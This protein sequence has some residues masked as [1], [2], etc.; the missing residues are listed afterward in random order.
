MKKI[1][2]FLL[3]GLGLW[4]MQADGQKCNAQLCTGRF[5]F[6]ARWQTHS[7]HCRGNA[8]SA[9]ATGSLACQDENGQGD[10]IKHYRHVRFLE[11]SRATERQYDF[12]GNNDIAAFVKTAQEEG[13]WVILRPSP[14]VCA[15]WEFGGYPYW[16]QEEEGLIVR[17]K[18][19]KYIA[20]YKNY[21]REIGTQLATLQI[22]HGGNILMVQ[23]ENEYGFTATIR[24]TWTLT[25]K[26][27]STP[28]LMDSCSPATHRLP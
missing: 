11:P 23:I 16:L 19:P 4:V 25:G 2:I 3:L 18:E 24:T 6:S 1:K 10:G 8:L 20:E 9:R 5:C 26:C 22:N 15:E 28:A 17:S 13:L 7:D 14:Y 12:T 21:I 27:S